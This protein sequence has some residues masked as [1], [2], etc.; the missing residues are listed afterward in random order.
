MFWFPVELRKLYWTRQ[1]N[2]LKQGL[3]EN[4]DFAWSFNGHGGRRLRYV[5]G[6][7]ISFFSDQRDPKDTRAC[8][9]LVVCDLGESGRGDLSIVWQDFLYVSMTV[10]YVAGFL[11][12]REATHYCEMLQRLSAQRPD[13]MPDVILFDGNGVLHPNGFGVASHVG[14]LSNQCTIG[15]S[16][17][18]HLVDGLDREWIKEQCAS[19][20]GGFVPLLGSSGRTWGAAVI[21][22]PRRPVMKSQKSQQTKNPIYVSVG[23]RIG[24]ESCVKVVNLCLL[25]ARVPEPVRLADILSRE[26]IRKFKEEQRQS[27]STKPL[28]WPIICCLSAGAVGVFFLRRWR[29]PLSVSS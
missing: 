2:Q 11:A 22:V 17:N 28:R 29:S 16:K 14:V 6:V 19:C 23:H 26:Q 10:P 7:D 21:P 18:L 25:S 5:G 3:I 24:L 8:A 20:R 13:L 15:V 12:F 27:A 1:Q 4:D 9:S